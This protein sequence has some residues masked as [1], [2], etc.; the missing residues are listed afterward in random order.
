MA[1]IPFVR[2][3]TFAY[4]APQ[5]VSPLIERVVSNNPGPFTFHGTGVYIIGRDNVAMIDPGPDMPG[6]QDMLRAALGGRR[7]THIFLTHGHADHS[8]AAYPLAQATGAKIFATPAGS[9]KGKSA[10]THG[11]QPPLEAGD[12]TSFHFDHALSDGD[13]FEGDGWTIEAIQTPGHTSN[14]TCFALKEENALF[15]GDHI[16]GWSTTVIT[17]PDGDMQ[18]YFDSLDK[19]RARNF[20]TLWP[21]HGPPIRTPAPF[22]DAYKE[23]RLAREAQIVAQI[24]AGHRKI[25]DM[26]PAMYVDVDPRLHPAAA[27]SVFAHMRRLVGAGVLAT[28]GE[29]SLDSLYELAAR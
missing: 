26:I 19:V 6:Q 24:R 21:T 22:I 15:S 10:L 8:P 27:M 7:L 25:K 12:D 18:A 9:S 14:H 17:P 13:R 28:E 2:E 16:M 1:G 11:D 20:D 3:M 5:R 23:H 4:G 29:P